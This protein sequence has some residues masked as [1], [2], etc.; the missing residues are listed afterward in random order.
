MTT[1]SSHFPLVSKKKVIRE[2]LKSNA[3]EKRMRSEKKKNG[4]SFLCCP[5][6]H[7]FEI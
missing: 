3:K 5:S 7:L 1:L 2:S 6:K 4:F